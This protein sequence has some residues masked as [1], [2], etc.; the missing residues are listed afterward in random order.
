MDEDLPARSRRM[1][2]VELFHLDAR[3]P[4]SQE[5]VARADCWVNRSAEVQRL[6]PVPIEAEDAEKRAASLY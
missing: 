2:R 5:V 6:L 4:E 3:D 1:G